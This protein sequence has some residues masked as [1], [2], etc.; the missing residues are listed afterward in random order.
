MNEVFIEKDKQ[1]LPEKQDNIFTV[2]FQNSI[3]LK[4]LILSEIIYFFDKNIISFGLR[5]FFEK[6]FN[7]LF[8]I[9]NPICVV[10]TI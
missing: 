10:F 2:S 8:I 9:A 4:P 1:W 6:P 3:A 5:I 7:V